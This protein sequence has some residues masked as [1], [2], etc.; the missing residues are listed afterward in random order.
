MIMKYLRVD[1]FFYVSCIPDEMCSNPESKLFYDYYLN[2]TVRYLRNCV[3]L[4][5]EKLKEIQ[6]SAALMFI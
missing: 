3:N 5:I 6:K 1:K 4:R 2:K